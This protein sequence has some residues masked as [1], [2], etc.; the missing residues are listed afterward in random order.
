MSDRV[1]AANANCVGAYRKLAQHGADGAVHE[2]GAATAFVTGL[3]IALF[4]GCL[5]LGSTAADVDLALDW[6][7]GHDVPYLLWMDSADAASDLGA[8]ARRRG[9]QQEPWALPG[10]VLAP[11][12]PPTP[13]DRVR[14]E[15]VDSS[16]LGAWLA[17]I[18]DDGMPLPL[19]ERLFPPSFVA[20]P[21]V[22][23]FAGY[24]DD[25]PVGTSI[26]IRT[27]AVA[28]VYAVMTAP[29]ERR[30]GVGTA[31]AWAAVDAGRTW[32]CHL[33]TLQA[34]EMGLAS[35]ARM[36][37]QTVLSYATFASA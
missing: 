31:A 16:S 10:M 11:S 5:T 21:D 27:G 13:P 2:F 30:N 25:Q 19:A 17:I 34:T 37:F 20:D 18:A 4:N 7:D 24:L 26:A 36:G 9:L 28:G 12:R 1:T 29:A 32:G 15:R 14:I 3:P 22:A 35:Y 8:L 23:A 33:V 6:I